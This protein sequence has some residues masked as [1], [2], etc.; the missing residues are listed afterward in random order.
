MYTRALLTAQLTRSR[1]NVASIQGLHRVYEFRKPESSKLKKSVRIQALHSEQR[2]VYCRSLNPQIPQWVNSS[3]R[4]LL[5]SRNLYVTI[6]TIITL[7][8]PTGTL[9]L[10]FDL[11]H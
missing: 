11:I 2:Y 10:S 5:N 7:I 8:H 9:K 1:M 6:T 4:N 3:G